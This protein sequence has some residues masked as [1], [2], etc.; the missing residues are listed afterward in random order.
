MAS[1]GIGRI[2][3]HAEAF[4]SSRR[5][6]GASQAAEKPV[7]TVILSMDSRRAAIREVRNGAPRGKTEG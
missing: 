2:S 1:A 5:K 3:R 4:S 7:G 6:G